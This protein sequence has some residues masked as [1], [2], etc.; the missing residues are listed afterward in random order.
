MEDI[1]DIG[2]DIADYYTA[3]YLIVAHDVTKNFQSSLSN[4]SGLTTSEIEILN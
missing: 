4:N 1:P 3:I 2:K